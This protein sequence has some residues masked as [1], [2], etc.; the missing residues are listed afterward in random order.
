MG[1]QGAVEVLHGREIQAAADPEAM[2]AAKIREYQEKFM[3][4]F[5]AAELGYVDDIIEPP[6]TR[7]CIIKG[8]EMLSTK[9]ET[10]PPRKHGNIPL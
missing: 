10:L 7:N 8:L 4:P 2:T 1:A 3:N 5:R 9:R 6:A